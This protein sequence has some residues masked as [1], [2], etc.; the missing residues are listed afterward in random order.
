MKKKFLIILW[1]I[2]C[3]GD[4]KSQNQIEQYQNPDLKAGKKAGNTQSW[5]E[6]N[7]SLRDS[8]LLSKV[9][10]LPPGNC[11]PNRVHIHNFLDT[12]PFIVQGNNL[13]SD[14]LVSEYAFRK[15][16]RKEFNSL[17][18]GN[19]D[20]PKIQK[21]A[22]LDLSDKPSFSFSPLNFESD[23]YKKIYTDIVS[24]NFS[25]KLNNENFIRLSDWRDLTA[26]FAW[27]HILN[28]TNYRATSRS[29]EIKRKDSCFLSGKI[30][31]WLDDKLESFDEICN[32]PCLNEKDKKRMDSA[33]RSEAFK[34]FTDFENEITS[35]YWKIKS[36]FWYSVNGNLIR[37]EVSFL[38]KPNYLQN[39]YTPVKKA[40]FTPSLNISFN[41][42][43]LNEKSNKSLFVSGW[44]E[45]KRKHS[46]SEIF[47]PEDFQPFHKINDSTYHLK[48]NESVFITD[49]EEL[50]TKIICDFGVR[51]I[52]MFN[53]SL[54]EKGIKLGGSLSFSRK[55][56]VNNEKFPSLFRTEAG[57]IIPMIQA[58]GET[59]LNIEIFR[60]WDN[61]SRFSNENGRLYGVRLNVPINN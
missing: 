57:I 53:F 48:G 4:S 18:L 6:K 60:R 13:K 15:L 23:P 7:R 22:T 10:S 12:I 19:T 37:D 1:G 54:K 29:A 50:N 56:L 49:F 27:I 33:L 55:G 39:Q 51:L 28:K 21:Y 52:S 9:S 30:K 34:E 3:Y 58:D 41:W 46:L 16:I 45:I 26:G 8:F 11:G 40:V 24:I 20:L 42:Y 61:F 38:F 17:V 25:G 32:N 2:A 59:Y 31:K 36:F 44:G 35:D 5:W 43:S 47:E 14:K